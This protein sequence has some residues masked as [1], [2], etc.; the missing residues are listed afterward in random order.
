MNKPAAP[1]MDHLESA[2]KAARECN[3]LTEADDYEVTAPEPDDF[4]WLD[5]FLAIAAVAVIGSFF[6]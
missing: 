3:G 4:R 5:F 2:A 6:I 1:T